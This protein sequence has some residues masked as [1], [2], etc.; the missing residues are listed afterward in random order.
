MW[1]YRLIQY[2]QQ[3]QSEFLVFLAFLVKFKLILTADKVLLLSITN[4]KSETVKLL[5]GMPFTSVTLVHSISMGQLIPRELYIL[6]L[7]L[8]PRFMHTL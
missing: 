2:L 5:I 7:Q 4:Q 3:A 6:V 8:R 1:A